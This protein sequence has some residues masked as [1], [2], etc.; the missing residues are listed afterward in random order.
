[1]PRTTT[2]TY[3]QKQFVI[4][5]LACGLNGKQAALDVGYSEKSAPSYGSALVRKPHIAAAIA[6]EQDRMADVH[7]IKLGHHLKEL[8]RLRDDAAA[9]GAFQAAVT[10]EV[11][12]GETLGFYRDAIGN[13][14][15][16]FILQIGGIDA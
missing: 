2:L 1:M 7:G 8:E 11:K 10:A 15:Q 5:Y 3:R 16:N 9:K 12:R 6:E 13:Q 14:S 4:A